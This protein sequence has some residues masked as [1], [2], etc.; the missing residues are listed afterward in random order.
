MSRKLSVSSVAAVLFVILLLVS[1]LYVLY[2]PRRD[3]YPEYDIFF[4]AF[5]QLIGNIFFII[6][7]II[8]VG[9]FIILVVKRIIKSIHKGK[10]KSK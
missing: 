8:F 7:Y 4:M 3:L 5:W 1:I 10:T 6:I 9:A 2:L